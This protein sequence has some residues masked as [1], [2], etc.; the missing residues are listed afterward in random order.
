MSGLFITATDTEIGKTVVT[1]AIAAALQRRGLPVGVMKPVA[2][3]GV[4]CAGTA[5]LVGEDATFLLA[6]AGLGE[7]ERP[8]VNPVCL[9]PALTPRIA[10]EQTGVT[11]D[12]A[13]FRDALARLQARFSPVLVEGVGGITAPIWQ[14]Y[15]VADMARDFALPLVVVARPVLG[16]INHT[17]LTVAY[18]RVRGLHVAGVIFNGWDEQHAGVLERTNAALTSELAQVPI[19]GKF[20]HLPGVSVPQCKLDGLAEAA[21]EHIDLDYLLEICQGEGH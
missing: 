20:P 16:A 1:G 14:K 13:V 4:R 21:E 3:G 2:S 18:A 11:I 15:L 10:A 19:I 6:A 7:T 12:P 8:L 9:A 17:V 5:G